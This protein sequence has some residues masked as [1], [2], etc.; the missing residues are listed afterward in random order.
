MNGQKRKIGLS[1][2]IVLLILSNTAGIFKLLNN[3]EMF[4][5]VYTLFTVAQ[6]KWLVLVPVSTILS[7]VA[8]WFGR[9]W[10]VGLSLFLYV[11]VMYLDVRYRVWSHAT[12][13]TVAFALLMFFCWQSRQFFIRE[14][15]S[16]AT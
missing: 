1:I 8:I 4:S 12:L 16:S 7:L 15:A 3:A 9:I 5:K 2:I 13:A 6:V 11:V 10:G 14:M